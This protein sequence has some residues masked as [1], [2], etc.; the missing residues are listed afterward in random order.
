MTS[1]GSKLYQKKDIKWSYRKSSGWE[2][3]VIYTVQLEWPL[4]EVKDLNEQM[5]VELKKRRSTQPLDQAS[6]GSVFKNPYPQFSGE[7]IEKAGLKG[8]TRGSAQVSEKHANFILN[9]DHAKAQDIHDLIQEIRKKVYDKFAVS[10]ET[11][12]HYMGRWNEL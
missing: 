4:E 1:E 5:K 8:L 2:K 3:G 11:E 6:C 10:L 9:L 12:V 7:L